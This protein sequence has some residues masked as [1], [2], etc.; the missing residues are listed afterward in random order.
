MVLYN[1]CFVTIYFIMKVKE[2]GETGEG[3]VKLAEY[4]ISEPN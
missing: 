4:L 2:I 3:Q 1:F